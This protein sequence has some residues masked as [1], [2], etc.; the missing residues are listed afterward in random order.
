MVIDMVITICLCFVFASE[1]LVELPSFVEKLVQIA[2]QKI[3]KCSTQSNHFG[4]NNMER[5][6]VILYG[7]IYDDH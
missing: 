1:I 2:C 6:V 5:F 7:C 3:G 4:M